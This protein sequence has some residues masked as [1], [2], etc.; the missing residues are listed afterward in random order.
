MGTENLDGPAP[1]APYVLLRLPDA[2]LA[3]LRPGDLI[4]RQW[5]SAVALQDDRISEAHAMVSLRG[6]DLR[7]LCLRGA[8]AVGGSLVD[9][10]VLEP[11]L[12]FELAPGVG[13]EVVEVRLPTEV[14]A[15][16]GP[17][18]GTRALTGVCSLRLGDRP[19]LVAGHRSQADAWFF[20]DGHAWFMRCGGE[21]TG[22][23]TPGDAITLGGWTGE[24]V[25]KALT[26]GPETVRQQA[27]VPLRIES[28]Y[29]TVRFFRDGVLLVQLHGLG[30][31]LVSELMEFDQPVAWEVVAEQ[32]WKDSRERWVLRRRWDTL[33]R[34]LRLALDE[35][36]VRSDLVCADGTGCIA[37]VPYPG[38][39]LVVEGA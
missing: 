37:L 35:G 17:G 36:G 21:V 1:Q 33:L 39:E 8:V 9:D 7:L 15:I 16:R 31:K 28:F 19:R 3:Q 11:G 26:G 38:D 29:D 20:D 4:G 12:R 34:R 10:P 18:I 30:A 22:P 32:L 14:I 24:V 5:T 2:S 13:F 25:L 23:L 6:G 27:Y